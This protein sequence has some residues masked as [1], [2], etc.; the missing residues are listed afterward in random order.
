M[1]APADSRFD[2]DAF[3]AQIGK[4]M[5]LTTE[6]LVAI[7]EHYI[8]RAVEVAVDGAS[9]KLTYETPTLEEATETRQDR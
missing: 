6:G 1:P 3:A 2:P 9:A 4:P 7:T 5:L 8:L